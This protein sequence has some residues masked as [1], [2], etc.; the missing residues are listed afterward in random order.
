M[1]ALHRLPFADA[2]YALRLQSGREIRLPSELLAAPTS[3]TALE[4]IERRCK[5]EASLWTLP[6]LHQLF[7]DDGLGGSS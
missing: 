4:D 1:P 6:P 7:D 5:T 2:R 3:A